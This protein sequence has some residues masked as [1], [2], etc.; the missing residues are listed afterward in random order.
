MDYE[1]SQSF[2][3][4]GY[5]IVAVAFAVSL[6][7]IL[8]TP[9]VQSRE[10]LWALAMVFGVALLVLNLL[11]LR[12]RISA[13]AVHVRFG[14]LIPYFWKRIPLASIHDSRVVDYRPLRDSGGWGIRLGRLNGETAWFYTARGSRGVALETDKGLRV[15]GSAEPEKLERALERALEKQRKRNR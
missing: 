11:H 14:L 9:A 4:I 5:A 12:L 8:T 2:G 1:E 3:W 10:S 15:V 6:V 13:D 7:A